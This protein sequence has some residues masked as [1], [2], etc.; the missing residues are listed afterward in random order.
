MPTTIKDIARRTGL[1]LATISKYL[2]GGNVREKNRVAIEAA[3]KELNY[4]ANAFARGLKTNRSQTIG[5]LIPELNNIFITTIIT[6]M[7]EILRTHGYAVL[8]SDCGGNPA[9]EQEAVRFLLQKGVDGLINMPLC[10]DGTHL[11][12]AIERN[13]PV[14]LIDRMTTAYRDEVSAVMVDN[15]E[16]AQ[17]A[18]NHL[19]ENG[20]EHIG[21]IIG[22]EDIFTSQQRL[23]GYRQALIS[24]NIMPQQQ[25]ECFSDYTLQGGYSATRHLLQSCP[26]MTA[27][28]TTN[29]EMTLG[30]II[31]L[32]EERVELPAGLSLIG[33]D[34]LQ[35]AQVVRPHLTIITQPLREI[36]QEAAR[37]ILAQLLPGERPAAS[38]V[39][40]HTHL[41]AGESV[42]KLN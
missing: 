1:G 27:L 39:V 3:I 7:E 20:H 17:N 14:I 25:Y 30:S 34:N 15:V 16:A 2:N 19:I 31:A 28:F 4:S 12:P 11:A 18:T 42:R 26:G 21:I 36:G 24:H 5:I 13:V 22:P 33:F 38:T 41:Q 37:L 10:Q 35:L 8:V 40:L 23:L 9:H 32:N 29:Y 6:V